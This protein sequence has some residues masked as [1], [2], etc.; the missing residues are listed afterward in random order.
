[1]QGPLQGN[2]YEILDV[3]P[4][5]TAEQIHKAYKYCLG[6]YSEGALATYTLLEPAELKQA[7]V[8]IQEAYDVLSDPVRRVDYDARNGLLPATLPRV[9]PAATLP[10]AAPPPPPAPAAA[11]L[12]TPEPAPLPRVT[13]LPDPVTG[14][15]L[16]RCREQRGVT[17]QQIAQRSKIGVRYFEYIEADRHTSL[18]ARV[19]LRGF[20]QEYARAVGLDPIKTAEAYLATLPQG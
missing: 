5:A 8:Q 6:M 12:P 7:R 19:Y 13:T 18:P 2:F 14:A 17:L 9:P 15:A 20:L 4:H 3:P 10:A 16:R 11:P 1:M